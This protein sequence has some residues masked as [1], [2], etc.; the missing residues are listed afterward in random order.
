MKV[1]KSSL[2]VAATIGALVAV[3]AANP[4]AATPIYT[5]DPQAIPG[6]LG[7]ASSVNATD[8][9]IS[10]DSTITQ[11][12]ATTQTEIGVGLVTGIADNGVNISDL[13]DGVNGIPSASLICSSFHANCGYNLFISF[14]A[15]V[16]GVSGF[17]PS[18]LG[19]IAPG[20]FTYELLADVG[21]NDT[22]VPGSTSGASP[23]ISGPDTLTVLA[24]GSS[25]TGSAGVQLSTQAPTLSA[26]ST[27][28]ICDGPG[29]GTINGQQLTEA[30][31]TSNL[32]VQYF[33][34]PVP[35]YDVSFDSAT[36]GGFTDLTCTAGSGGQCTTAHYATL[37]GISADVNF[38]QVP[39]PQT[40]AM[41]GFGLIGLG[42]FARRRVR[43]S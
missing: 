43:N 16:N 18:A 15:T 33:T 20:G 30:Q 2:M 39:E 35:F 6:T 26:L 14:S 9:T 17:S 22:V 25:L 34:A 24:V 7:L 28:V 8:N 3:A 11:T 41:F 4:A 10:T 27:F 38:T 23:T 19:T 1:L 32:G 37:N 5:F 42:W 21:A 29:V 13:V 40:L 12:T 36:A 31:C